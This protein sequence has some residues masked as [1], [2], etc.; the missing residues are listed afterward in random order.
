MIWLSLAAHA[1]EPVA[2]RAIVPFTLRDGEPAGMVPWRPSF[3]E[4]ALIAVRVD[5]ATRVPGQG[6][7]PSYWLGDQPLRDWGFDP[8]K[9]CA[10]FL[11]EGPVDLATAPWF[12]GPPELPERLTPA[13]VAARVRDAVAA[14][15][16]PLDPGAVAAARRPAVALPH[17]G[18][19]N[20]LADAEQAACT[21]APP[22]KVPSPL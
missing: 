21:G 6:P 7:L 22:P 3:D 17:A 11:V 16:R 9:G 15:A 18:A 8:A 14:G 1:A 20:A 13:L 4:G 5:P 19:L 2:I 10:V 12:L